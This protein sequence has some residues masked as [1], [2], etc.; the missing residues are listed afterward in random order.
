MQ[1]NCECVWHVL[2]SKC[3]GGQIQY[4]VGGLS[5]ISVLIIVSFH[6]WQHVRSFSL[7]PSL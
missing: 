1:F 2:L 7:P 5:F 4:L 3:V 6:L